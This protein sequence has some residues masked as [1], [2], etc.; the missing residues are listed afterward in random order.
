MSLEAWGFDV[1]E[2]DNAALGRAR[3]AM[4]K[5][6]KGG[7]NRDRKLI[8]NDRRI[9]QLQELL[10]ALLGE[11]GMIYA[12]RGIAAILEELERAIARSDREE[13]R[14]ETLRK[15]GLKDEKQNHIRPLRRHDSKTSTSQILE[16]TA[17]ELRAKGSDA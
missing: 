1:F 15:H 9:Y 12:K 7:E 14:E 4:G 16:E 3:I 8:L 10:V 2:S 13:E 5:S 17:R 11:P 6:K